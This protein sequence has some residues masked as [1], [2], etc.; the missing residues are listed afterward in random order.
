MKT[1]YYNFI[2]KLSNLQDLPL[3][4]IRLILAF[5]FYAPA[6]AKLQNVHDIAIWFRSLEIPAPIFMAYLTTYTEVFGFL[7]LIFGFATRFITI[8]LM[9]IMVVAIKTVHWG[10]GFNAGDNGFEIPLYYLVMLLLLFIT[11][12]GKISVDY[13]MGRKSNVN[14]K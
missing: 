10:N 11:G 3:L 8:P 7:F 1:K 9:I 2:S 14:G 13:L 5:G 4:L 6:M 12:P